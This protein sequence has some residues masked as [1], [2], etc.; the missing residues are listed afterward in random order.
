MEYP[1]SNSHFQ[2]ELKNNL[3]N[4]LLIQNNKFPKED[5]LK[6]DLYSKTVNSISP[7]SFKTA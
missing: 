4:F 1:Q 6:I 2:E 5:I 3:D 7:A